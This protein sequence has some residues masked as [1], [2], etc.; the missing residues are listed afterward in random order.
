M[1]PLE[2]AEQFRGVG[3]VEARTVVAPEGKTGRRCPFAKPSSMRAS[4]RSRVNF[5]ALPS[6]FVE[7]DA[8]QRLS[9]CRRGC[10]DRKTDVPTGWALFSRR[11]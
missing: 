1:E 3:H 2:H 5:Q 9:P 8:E 6:R 4:S 7:H 10:G 11:R